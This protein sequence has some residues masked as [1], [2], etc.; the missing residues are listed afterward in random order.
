MF[1]CDPKNIFQFLAHF[2]SRFHI[3]E[4]FGP[5]QILFLAVVRPGPYTVQILETKITTI[6]VVL[7]DQR[8]PHGPNPN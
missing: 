5:D 7:G 8:L 2:R 4:N 6:A 3:F 1:L